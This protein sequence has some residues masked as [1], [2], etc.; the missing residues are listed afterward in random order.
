MGRDNQ[1]LKDS[2]GLGY[3]R[4]D[5]STIQESHLPIINEKGMCAG[6]GLP[7]ETFTW[8][9]RT[10]PGVVSAFEKVYETEDLIV[11]FDAVNMSFPN[12][13]DLK[14]NTPWPHQDQDRTRPGFR[15]LQGLVNLLPNGPD[16]G[17]L[18]VCKGGHQLSEEFHKAFEDETDRI[19]AW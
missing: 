7:H 13:K 18:I 17:G 4:H 6:Y 2:S 1:I 5:P 15:C 3:D 16:D 8:A 19:W 14:A 10:E 9:I 11:S 12:R